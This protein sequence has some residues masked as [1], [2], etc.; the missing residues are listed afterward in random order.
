MAM[1]DLMV[2]QLGSP[3]SLFLYV[4]E[5]GALYPGMP[6]ILL[7]IGKLLVLLSKSI[8]MADNGR[9]GITLKQSF[10]IVKLVCCVADDALDGCVMLAATAMS[11]LFHECRCNWEGIELGFPPVSNTSK[12]ARFTNLAS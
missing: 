6:C 1:L 8:E 12:E 9:I 4:H 5:L 11:A 7:G 3:R 10:P 2:F